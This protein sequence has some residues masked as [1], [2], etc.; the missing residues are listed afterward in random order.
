VV[1]CADSD[2]GGYRTCK[3]CKDKKCTQLSQIAERAGQTVRRIGAGF[4]YAGERPAL[5]G[6]RCAS[7]HGFSLHANVAVPAPRRDQVERLIFPFAGFKPP[8]SGGQ[9]SSPS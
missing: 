6:T 8:P 3:P 1:D 2:C 5:T 7:V 4:D 9:I